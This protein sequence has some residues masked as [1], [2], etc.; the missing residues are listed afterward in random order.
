MLGLGDPGSSI[1]FSVTLLHCHPWQYGYPRPLL[2][3]KDAT[4]NTLFPIKTMISHHEP[5]A[6]GEKMSFYF[7]AIFYFSIT[8]LRRHPCQHRYLRPQS[9]VKYATFNTLLPT[10]TTCIHRE[11]RVS[12]NALPLLVFLC[13]LA[14]VEHTY[15]GTSCWMYTH[16]VVWCTCFSHAELCMKVFSQVHICTMHNCTLAQKARW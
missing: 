2:E 11:C 7:S 15:G 9:E 5:W 12:K 3:L 1:Y 6:Q 10:S 13:T 4:F 14:P 8:L 16:D